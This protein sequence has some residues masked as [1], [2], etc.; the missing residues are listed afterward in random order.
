M[1]DQAD[2]CVMTLVSSMMIAR[3]GFTPASAMA[4]GTVR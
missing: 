4:S 3:R 2:N 1:L